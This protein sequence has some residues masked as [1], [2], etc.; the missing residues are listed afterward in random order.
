MRLFDFSRAPNPRRVRMYLAEKGMEIP[1]VAVNL[2]RMEQL[3]P[4]FLAI[5][6]GGTVPVLELDDGTRLTE[7]LAICRYLESLQPEPPL[8]GQGA[9]GEA[10]VLMWNNI[11]EAEGIPSAAEVLRNLSPGFRDRVFPGPVDYPQLPALVQ[12]GAIRTQQ[13]FDRIQARLDES[14]FLAGDDFSFADISL[15]ATVDFAKWVD[16]DA[17][18]DRPAIARWYNNV[19][20][21][22]ST[23]A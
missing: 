14:P 10:L 23:G 5:N 6:P 11:V 2:Y 8:F 13:F 19:K 9:K 7:C 20:S 3:S 16:I 12:R 17:A 18:Q 22:P 15:V 21:R 4:E 1:R